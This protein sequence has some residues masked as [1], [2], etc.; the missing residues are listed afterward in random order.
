MDGVSARRPTRVVVV[1][2]VDVVDVETAGHGATGASRR[3]A[4][5]GDDETSGW[6]VDVA[7]Q[8]TGCCVLDDAV[9]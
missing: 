8:G 1:A 2:E 9:E 5:A 7:G 6:T 4:M 3:G